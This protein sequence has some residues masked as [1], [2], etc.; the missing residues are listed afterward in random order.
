VTVSAGAGGYL[1]VT[2]ALFP[3]NDALTVWCYALDAT[4]T[5]PIASLPSYATTSN[6]AGGGTSA[7]CQWSTPGSHAFVTVSGAGVPDDYPGLYHG[8]GSNHLAFT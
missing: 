4:G 8:V 2:L 6:A 1:V 5:H 7:Q 3:P